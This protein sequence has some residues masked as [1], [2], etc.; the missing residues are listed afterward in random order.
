MDVKDDA[1]LR[2]IFDIFDGDGNQHLDIAELNIVMRS[3]GERPS[4]LE[5]T[6]LLDHKETRETPVVAE[7]VTSHPVLVS[8]PVHQL[9]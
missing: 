4:K 1:Q 8:H 3:L 6:D 5:L 2:E 9:C 7:D